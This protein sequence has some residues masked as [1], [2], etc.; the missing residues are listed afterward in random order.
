MGYFGNPDRVAFG[1]DRRI[2]GRKEDGPLVLTQD[3][4]RVVRY[5]PGSWK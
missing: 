4:S 1:G 2:S 3:P 5:V